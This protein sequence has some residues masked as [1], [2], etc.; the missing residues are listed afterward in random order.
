VHFRGWQSQQECARS[1]ADA[2]ALVLPSL[3]ECGGAVVLEAMAM[4]RPVIATAWGGPADYLDS[5]TGFLIPPT[6][7]EA[8]IVGFAEAMQSLIDNPELAARMGTAAREKLLA[9]FTWQMKI[10]RILEIYE[11]VIGRT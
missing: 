7:R 6:S 11:S 2:T 4:A 3:Y 1:L 10:D 9:Q 5:E 8:M